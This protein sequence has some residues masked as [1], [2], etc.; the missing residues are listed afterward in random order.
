MLLG[1]IPLEA[2]LQLVMMLLCMHGAVSLEPG[3]A[4]DHL[5]LLHKLKFDDSGLVS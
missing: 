2:A 5:A 1:R 4:R 3:P